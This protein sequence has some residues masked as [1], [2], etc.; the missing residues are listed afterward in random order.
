M[1][2]GFIIALSSALIRGLDIGCGC[3]SP[4]DQTDRIN[5]LKIAEDLVLL[6]M[7]MQVLLVKSH[8]FSIERF[9][10]RT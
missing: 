4:S 8:I 6:L 9:F 3:F 1:T 7:I 5:L 2:A 10:R